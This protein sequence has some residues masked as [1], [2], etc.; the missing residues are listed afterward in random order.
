VEQLRTELRHRNRAWAQ[1]SQH[2]AELSADVSRLQY[3]ISERDSAIDWVV[4]SCL[5]AWDRE[6][7]A[8]AHVS[9]LRAALDSL[10]VYCNTLH[11]EVHVLYA[12][13]HP[14]VPSDAAAM[15]ARPSGTASEGPDGDFDLF[16]PLP[17]MNLA[18]ERSPA[19]GN[20]VSKDDE[21]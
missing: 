18:D 4:N 8:R 20:E 21:Y 5:I 6:A 1:D 9:E 7:K 13:L 14:D 3:E 11:E 10:Q 2:I 12:R 15:G 19:A 16:R 17:S